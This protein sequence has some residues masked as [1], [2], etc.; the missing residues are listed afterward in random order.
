MFQ[1]AWEITV[2]VHWKLLWATNFDVI[3]GFIFSHAGIFL[4]CFLFCVLRAVS[5]FVH[6]WR[7]S[8]DFFF[9][10]S[11]E[12]ISKASV[13][14]MFITSGRASKNKYIKWKD[15]FPSSYLW[16]RQCWQIIWIC[17]T[18]KFSSQKIAFISEILSSVLSIN[19]VSDLIPLDFISP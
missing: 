8:K 3:L 15:T 4:K 7:R 13:Y 18:A 17:L 2:V 1:L 11:E 5:L 6:P 12:S 14:P 10:L 9:F 16:S 19:L